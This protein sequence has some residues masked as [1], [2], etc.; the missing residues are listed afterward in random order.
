MKTINIENYAWHLQTFC[1]NALRNID[2]P[3]AM[4][5]NKTN[6]LIMAYLNPW[7]DWYL[8]QYLV[9]FDSKLNPPSNIDERLLT[10]RVYLKFFQHN[11]TY[12]VEATNKQKIVSME[13]VNIKFLND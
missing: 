8:Y 13:D 11:G 12:V 5:F 2:I 7:M 1:G 6:L 9:D 3:D 10:C 4:S